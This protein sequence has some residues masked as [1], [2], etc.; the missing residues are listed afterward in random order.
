MAGL[1]V[2]FQCVAQLISAH[3]WHHYV[4]YDEVG[5]VSLC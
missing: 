2:C 5:G 1:D 3:V 4:A